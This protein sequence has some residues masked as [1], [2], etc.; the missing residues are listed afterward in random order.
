MRP[1]III[2]L[3]LKILVIHRKHKIRPV[4]ALLQLKTVGGVLAL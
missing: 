4:F 1:P 3:L 2:R